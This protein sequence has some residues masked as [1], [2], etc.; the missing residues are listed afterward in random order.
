MTSSF[1][2]ISLAGL[3]TLTIALTSPSRV[4]A[5]GGPPGGPFG[6][7]SYFPNEGTFSAV[8]RGENLAG[9]LQFSTTSDAGP[10][11][12]TTA[13]GSTSTS[14]TGGVGSTGVSTIY[15]NGYTYFGNSQ[16]S[17]N[18]EP[19]DMSVN[20]QADVEG[21]GQQTFEVEAPVTTVEE[22]I[23]LNPETGESTTFSVNKTEIRPFRKILY[24]DSLYLNGYAE[25]ETS[26]AF[27]NQ[28]FEGKGQAEVQGLRFDG[29]T[30][31]INYAV[32]PISVT[33]VRI[34]DTASAF[35]TQSVRPPS[36][37]EYNIYVPVLP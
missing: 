35:A 37:N 21:Q 19:S 32:I 15:F 5:F 2:P 18:P 6:N 11:N 34:S 4:E 25:C 7:G 14:G 20:F 13:N 12:S 22:S 28:K 17:I 30:P 26:N 29:Y 27:P 36:Y 23:V 10:V 33:G 3:L 16:G 9:T 1:R 8:V 31:F 24:Y